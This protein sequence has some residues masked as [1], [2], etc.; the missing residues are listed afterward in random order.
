[1]I[2]SNIQVNTTVGDE[3]VVSTGTDEI[4]KVNDVEMWKGFE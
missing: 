3:F 2:I 4:D 1:M